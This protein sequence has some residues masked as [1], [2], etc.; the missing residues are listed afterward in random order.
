ML[1]FET[2]NEVDCLKSFNET[3]NIIRRRHLD[4]VPLMA[5]AVIRL[6]SGESL[7]DGVNDAIQ[8][9]LN[10]LYTNRI[11]I[12][13]LI[14][15]YNALCGQARTV[16]GMVGTVDQDCLISRVASLA[17]S[18]AANLCDGEY[19][20]HPEIKITALD[21]TTGSTEVSCVYVPSHLHHIFF[22]IFKVVTSL[23]LLI[24]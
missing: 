6:N 17:Y 7:T 9:F 2:Q 22:E 19:L 12:H 18:D 4:T 13:M 15:H 24:S 5:R 16:T 1:L 10:R 20:G 11:S 14:S 8:Y 23:H 3:L 21:T